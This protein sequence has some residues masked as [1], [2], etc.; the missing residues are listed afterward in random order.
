M[1][2]RLSE[3]LKLRVQAALEAPCALAHESP[4]RQMVP[5]GR[6]TRPDAGSLRFE[7]A[8]L[9]LA[10]DSPRTRIFALLQ[11]EAGARQLAP[12]RAMSSRRDKARKPVDRSNA[13]PAGFFVCAA[14]VRSGGH[15][16][17]KGVK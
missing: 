17:G 4:M 7:K 2:S 9:V 15:P 1:H 13:R 11:A 14:F 16:T 10:T 12:A 3:G 6:A 5:R 8:G